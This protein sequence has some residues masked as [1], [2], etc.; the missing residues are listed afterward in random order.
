M[1]LVV[2][3]NCWNLAGFW[4]LLGPKASMVQMDSQIISSAKAK[5]S[6]SK[7]LIVSVN[8]LNWSCT[9][10]GDSGKEDFPDEDGVDRPAGGLH[11]QGVLR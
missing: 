10:E 3:P 7:Q 11:G 1:Q 2:A 6:L 8:R 5:K 4:E 9:R